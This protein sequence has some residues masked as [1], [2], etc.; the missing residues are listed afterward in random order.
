MKTEQIQP[1]EKTLRTPLGQANEAL[2]EGDFRKAIT[3]YA[4]VIAK[5][6]KLANYLAANL[7]IAIAKAPELAN[8]L[9]ANLAIARKKSN[10]NRYSS[11]KPSV[12]VCGWDLS[13]NAAGRVYAL[14]TLYETFANVE[15]IGS[16]FPSH[17]QEIWE[18]IRDTPIAKHT[19]I[20]ENES[21]FLEKAIQLVATHPYDIV[22]LSKPRAPNIFFGT[23][24]K[25][26]WDATVL[27]DIDDEELSFVG[28]AT[29]IT[30]EDY[31]KRHGRLPELKNL[32]GNDWTRISVGLANGFDGLTVANHALQQRYGG[33]IIG[34]A[35]D[36]SHY[37][38]STQR[39]V[40]RAR[41]G[42]APDA[43]VV[44]FL[45]TPRI[46]KGLVETA[47]AIAKLKRRD[48]VYAIVGDFP[49]VKLKEKLQAIAGVNYAFI[50]NQPFAAVPEITAMAD[51]CV[52]LQDPQS[53]TARYQTPA[54]LSDA[55]SGGLPVLAT[56]T[57]ALAN[58]FIDGA[59]LPV[60]QNTLPQQL[61]RVLDNTDTLQELRQAGLDFF[62]RELSIAA[63]APRLRQAMEQSG[64]LPLATDVEK[65]ANNMIDDP[66]SALL[67]I[68]KKVENVVTLPY[69]KPKPISDQKIAVAVHVYYPD[70]WLDIA[71]RLKGLSTPFDLFVTTTPEHANAVTSAVRSDFPV[72]RIDI[73][74]NLGMDVVPFLRLVPALVDEG[75]LLVCKLHTKKGEDEQGGLWRRALMDSLIGNTSTFVHITA[76]FAREPSLQMAGP[77][78]LYLSA[79]KLMLEND[80]PLEALFRHLEGRSL[81]DV[82]W[83]FFSG[84][85]FWVRPTLLEKL[86][87]HVVQNLDQIETGYK[88]DGQLVHAIERLF[89]L[90]PALQHGKIGLLY[91]LQ[92]FPANTL[93]IVTAYTP[94]NQA[95]MG[96]LM[97]QYAHLDEDLTKL[98]D[99]GLFDSDYYCKQCP[100]LVG[101]TIDLISHY[102]LIGR[103][104]GNTPNPDFDLIF[105]RLQYADQLNGAEDPFLHY[106][107]HGAKAGLMLRSTKEKEVQ[108]IPSFRYRALNT[109][110]IDWNI[111]A[112]QKR[113]PEKTSI[114]IPVYNN[115]ELT[116][117]CIESLYTHTPADRFELIVVDNGSEGSTGDL[118]NQFAAQHPNLTVMHNKENFNFA[119]GC[120]LGFAISHCEKVLFLNNDTRVTA[121]WLEPLLNPLDRPEISAVQPLLLFPD[122]S[123]QCAGVVFSH[124]NPLGYPI[125]AGYQPTPR[126]LRPDRQFQA[127]SAACMMVRAADFCTCHGFDPV[128]INGQEDIDLC[129]RLNTNG[130]RAY[131]AISSK[132]IHHESQS[133]LRFYYV[134]Y[135]RTTFSHRWRGRV[136]H[137]DEL[138]FVEDQYSIDKYEPD[139]PPKSNQPPIYRPVLVDK[140]ESSQHGLAKTEAVGDNPETASCCPMGLSLRRELSEYVDIDQY[141][142]GSIDLVAVSNDQMFDPR[143]HLIICGFD[144]IFRGVR[145]LANGLTYLG[146]AKYLHR[147]P[148]VVRLIEQGRVSCGLEHYILFALP[149]STRV[150]NERF[151]E[152]RSALALTVVSLGAPQQQKAIESVLDAKR[153][154]TV[155]LVDLMS[156][157]AKMILGSW[158][159]LVQEGVTLDPDGLYTMVS[160]FNHDQEPQVKF[161]G[162]RL[163][164]GMVWIPGM[165]TK[166]DL[167]AAANWPAIIIPP[168]GARAFR[169]ALSAFHGAVDSRDRLKAFT[170]QLIEQGLKLTAFCDKPLTGFATPE[171]E[172]KFYAIQS[173]SEGPDERETLSQEPTVSIIIPFRDKVELL[174]C[175]VDSIISRTSY[176]NYEILLVDNNSI[177]LNT[178]NYLE[179]NEKLSDKIR[180]LRYPHS[181]NFAAINNFAAQYSGSDVLVLLN[182]D[183]EIISPDWLRRMATLAMAK[184]IGAVG[185]LLTYE[186]DEI[187]HAGVAIGMNGLVGHPYAGHPLSELQFN[188]KLS[189]THPVEAVTGACLA[190]ERK[191]FEH[192]GGLDE[193]NLSVALNDID[194][195]LRLAEQGR[196]NL[197]VPDLS[198]RHY[199]SQSRVWDC[200]DKTGR[201]AGEVDFFR[202]RHKNPLQRGDRFV[203]L[204]CV[205]SLKIGAGSIQGRVIMILAIRLLMGYGV[206]LVVHNQAARLLRKGAKVIV[207]VLQ[208]DRNY[209]GNVPYQVVEFNKMDKETLIGDVTSMVESERVD[210]VIAHTSPFFEI[211]PD[212]K[213]K[214]IT[215]VY[216][217]GD[218]SPELFPDDQVARQSIKDWKVANV[219]PE[220]DKVI[221]ISHF[222]SEDINW[223]QADIIY[224]GA[225][226]LCTTI[227]E[228]T[229]AD[230]KIRYGLNNP[231]NKMFLCVARL[232]K[233]E[234]Y[235]KGLDKFKAFKQAYALD[236]AVF[237]VIGRGTENDASD[238]RE[239][240]LHVLLNVSEVDLRCAYRAC[241]AFFSFSKWEGF[242]LPLVEA[243]CFGKPA[244]AISRCSHKEVTRNVFASVDDIANFI[245]DKTKQELAELGITSA[246]YIN[247][248]TWASN[249][250]SL[251]KTL[252][253]MIGQSQL[254][255]PII[256]GRT[257]ICILTKNKLEYIKPCIESLLPLK[258]MF[259]VEILIGDTGS[260]DAAVWGFYEAIASHA[261]IYCYNFYN[262]SKIN[263]YLANHANGDVLIFLNNDT[264]A[265]DTN[266]IKVIREVLS[267]S[268]VGVV[269]PM[270]LYGDGT[271]Q[272]AGVE[273][274][275]SNP[276]RYVGW[277]P[278]AKH[279]PDDLVP[280]RGVYS[281]PAVT[282]ACLA[283]KTELFREVGG[284]EEVY[285][286]E[287]QDV[288][289]CLKIRL[290][291]KQVIYSGEI[292]LFHYENGTRMISESLQ[293]RNEFRR[294]W[295]ETIELLYL[296]NGKQRLPY[297]K[298]VKIM[299]RSDD[300]ELLSRYLH[301]Y[302]DCEITISVLD[303]ANLSGLSKE[304]SKDK[305]RVLPSSYP[306]NHQYDNIVTC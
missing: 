13:H 140:T 12:A 151:K 32:H 115:P 207:G 273:I 126:I 112:G 146:E 246:I 79:R 214:V 101:T 99:S 241:D 133:Q 22:H 123:I 213:G 170:E 80:A 263:N 304:Y 175:C 147:Y 270:L 111:L 150:L 108:E 306:D 277:H 161:G 231:Q 297:K 254:T 191:K 105:Y 154:L 302:Y 198:I 20:V 124:K 53:T 250:R 281:V 200:Y 218:P 180:V 58:A 106:L 87:R 104:Q 54:K 157:Q 132:V 184:E 42:I 249:A 225:D 284:F 233:G 181:F 59:L 4:Q 144:E 205:E 210:I 26:L 172:R 221:A 186:A 10:S 220:V 84:T 131:V 166:F 162:V 82:D 219:Y 203:D 56:E 117:A 52:I 303:G 110:L 38:A 291:G 68:A 301:E 98:Q 245:R 204:H 258:Q 78:S 238:L 190:V 228:K 86:S 3:E 18:P 55:L 25:L 46:Y 208:Y 248:F 7:A 206:D 113:D 237:V 14:A 300:K 305:L 1:G 171:D 196:T 192:I 66:L 185:A 50:G 158:I 187:Q 168:N 234:R 286:E 278:Y 15:I 19:F 290:L 137:D 244:F 127:V 299:Y 243:Q 240:G 167:A 226:H 195:C 288:D 128:F 139:T 224:N 103:F 30:I 41:F 69:A 44:L 57:L 296:R 29:P 287:C 114:I 260:D 31:I 67:G 136:N 138:F 93:Q 253:L 75:Y 109:S 215:A 229:L 271:I 6:P 265:H 274:F 141:M 11:E 269:G 48:I 149:L 40:S 39:Q 62:R 174:R 76:A 251:A 230:F 119:L 134:A 97:R 73:Q 33:Q 122:G 36:E 85:M 17:A 129:L 222:I 143:E 261:Q 193:V 209:Y 211:L 223:P 235:Y 255:K 256:K 199:E 118:L 160:T 262:F 135:N 94:P 35:R 257:S 72:A 9:A 295:G 202:A 280:V 216:E 95:W 45:G 268:S 51:V 236:D 89:G 264:L 176:Q 194:L 163:C 24:Y 92:S 279:R 179:E 70:L 21:K 276:Y 266:W 37:P 88:K 43:K 189:V 152:L 164:N 159:A 153:F 60:N 120:N 188:W 165:A 197:L 81:P 247:K 267:G 8:Y 212:L 71:R 96:D 77:A 232:G 252:S 116:H 142:A 239:F 65:L 100:D 272:H 2:R 289:F 293:D 34:H 145:R 61:A 283:T 169:S 16:L 156:G 178:R 292:S 64:K 90:L 125:Y 27:M 227:D 298:S 148:E 217:H 121:N 130:R 47:Q 285:R 282:G 173:F 28:E 23:L 107:R 91:P 102:L 242:N 155:G 83:G 5:E 201:F 275:L 74:P 49:D 177:Q 183:T 182:N 259:D 294:R 63:N